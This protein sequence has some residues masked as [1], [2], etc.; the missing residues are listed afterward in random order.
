MEALHRQACRLLP[1]RPALQW[2]FQ[3]E[4]P[5][6][7]S[8]L[9]CVMVEPPSAE[10]QSPLGVTRALV[11]MVESLAS[12]LAA[13]EARALSSQPCLSSSCV[14]SQNDSHSP[15]RTPHSQRMICSLHS[16]RR[17]GLAVTSGQR[18]FQL[19][20]HRI[21]G[22][23][24]TT[25]SSLSRLHNAFRSKSHLHKRVAFRSHFGH[26]PLRHLQQRHFHRVWA[27]DHRA[28]RSR[29]CRIRSQKLELLPQKPRRGI[30]AH[31]TLRQRQQR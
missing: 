26:S 23:L 12:A 9:G 27:Q 8:H 20:R 14:R 17:L 10:R 29:S 24:T 28:T 4:V 11:A 18:R 22:L 5:Q 13:A 15:R 3:Q 6:Q 16:R 19:R 31:L 7:R 21:W 2:M 1:A 25:S 30:L